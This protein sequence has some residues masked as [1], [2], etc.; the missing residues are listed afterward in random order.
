MDNKLTKQYVIRYYYGEEMYE[1]LGKATGKDEQDAIEAFLG[2][3]ENKN[4]TRQ[5]TADEILEVNYG[6]Q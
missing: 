6:C 1:T 3:E 5:L 4:E 2:R